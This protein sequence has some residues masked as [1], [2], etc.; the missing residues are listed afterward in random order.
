ML[1]QRRKIGDLGENS[2]T[3]WCSQLGIDAVKAV[4]DRNGWDYLVEFERSDRIG[5]ALDAQHNLVK[6]H[7]QVK[8]T[9]K[10]NSKIS[11][12]LSA[13]KA[14][15]SVDAPA[16]AVKLEFG[17][18]S[19]PIRCRLLHI[20][21]PQIAAILKRVREAHR[22][23]SELHNINFSLPMEHA[24]TVDFGSEDL[25]SYIDECIGES[26]AKYILEK[27][28]IRKR[29]GYGSDAFKFSFSVEKDDN[30]KFV[31]FLIGKTPEIEVSNLKM[32]ESRFGIELPSQKSEFS[33]A[34]LKIIESAYRDVN[35]IARSSANGVECQVS[36]KLY[37]PPIP[38]LPK[39]MVKFRVSNYF[40]E[41]EISSTSDSLSLRLFVP[42]A[43]VMSIY[44]LSDAL[45]FMSTMSFSDSNLEIEFENG[46]F[47]G[48][49]NLALEGE[50]FI[51]RKLSGFAE[52]IT[53]AFSSARRDDPKLISLTELEEVYRKNPESRGYL[54]DGGEITA[55]VQLKENIRDL[56][57][58]GAILVPLC[59]D[60][61]EFSYIGVA[62]S[63]ISEVE[64]NSKNEL[65]VK[66][67]SNRVIERRILLPSDDNYKRANERVAQIAQMPD[68]MGKL[69]I[70]PSLV[71]TEEK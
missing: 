69:V 48:G 8:A 20:G 50:L 64:L 37:Y 29:V 52:E 45:K 55:R 41:I 51:Y 5:S 38:N 14:L 58:S 31:D 57:P 42:S 53:R 24:R 13:L 28:R 16:F 56:T 3:V 71:P 66:S 19:Y 26:P 49:R 65:V 54:E 36:A 60:F 27:E 21:E 6:A 62:K 40:L 22:D 2:F 70:C 18:G 32:I 44:K 68:N 11:G 39:D 47:A 46:S 9:E 15:V 63:D 1:K 59:F 43:E 67:R 33:D 34:K 61:E 35:V 17:N 7:V 23:G 30:K 10:V 4:P 25:R 12:K